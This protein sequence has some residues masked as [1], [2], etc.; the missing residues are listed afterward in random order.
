MRFDVIVIGAGVIGSAI[1]R[2]LARYELEVAVLEKEADVG[3]GASKANSAIVHTGFDAPPGSVEAF[4]V[5]KANWM[6]DDLCRE[7]EVP[8]QRRGA[9]LVATDEHEF[10]RLEELK[11]HGE[12][13]GVK[14]LRLISREELFSLEPRITRKALG[15]LRIPRESLVCPFTLVV[16]LME[17]AVANGVQLFLE[18]EAEALDIAAGE[19]KGVFTSAGYM[20]A[21]WVVNAAGL[22]ADVFVRTGGRSDFQ[23]TPRKGEF[24][25]LDKRYQ[26]VNHIILPVPTP[27]SKGILVAP[28]VDGNTIVGPT[29]D[30]I[31]DKE[32]R[33]VSR[34]GLWRAL[35]G[36]R[37]LVPD[38]DPS[39]A[40]AQFA[41]CRAAGN[42]P[43][44]L[45]E[46]AS[47]VRGLIH[48]ANIRSTGVTSSPAVAKRV[49]EIL[50]HQG[51]KLRPKTN[52][53]PRRRGLR[54]F[55]ELD[56]VA[57]NALIRENPAYGRI[58]CRCEM[59]T[60]AEVVEALHRIP[61][62]T[63]LDAVKRRTRAG[64]GRCQGGF[65]TP[66]IVQIMSRELGVPPEEITK[67]GKGSH[68]FTGKTRE[69]RR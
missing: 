51:E 64:M 26:L 37:K 40:I 13:N 46:P 41:G 27:V 69:I 60:E 44:Y 45:L 24:W 59:V 9:L 3:S 56:D 63:T 53:Q 61:P 68:L 32:D 12:A 2:E 4:M 55:S 29:A 19:V 47:S 33:G 23:V 17:N 54:R 34:D 50:R 25:V 49:I 5:T 65:C 35:E 52:F 66:R 48:A 67:K 18:T 14:D 6:F 36:G 38:L 16:A 15:A 62:A 42:L 21:R 10:R 31:S 58:V 43:D 11:R 20:A 22:Y 57:R 1:A 7:L 30:N 28:T 8:F 39:M